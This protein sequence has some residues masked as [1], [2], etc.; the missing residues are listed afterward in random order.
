MSIFFARFGAVWLRPP[1]PPSL[2][3]SLW[4]K[5]PLLLRWS[6]LLTFV[7]RPCRI[8]IQEIVNDDFLIPNLTTIGSKT[9]TSCPGWSQWR[10]HLC[11]ARNVPV[12]G[13]L[14]WSCASGVLF[15]QKET[16]GDDREHYQVHDEHVY[17]ILVNCT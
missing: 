4:S 11:G 6:R 5:S 13:Q 10:A 16:G 7:C 8:K 15:D 1:S 3:S 9:T 17:K 2:P 12:L 14:H